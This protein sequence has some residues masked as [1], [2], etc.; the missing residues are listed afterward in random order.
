MNSF[1][2]SMTPEQLHEVLQS[3]LERLGGVEDMTKKHEKA[4]KENETQSLSIK[5]FQREPSNM[6]SRGLMK[7]E[8][9]MNAETSHAA[10]TGLGLAKKALADASQALV[11]AQKATDDVNRMSAQVRIHGEW[12][13]LLPT[14]L[15]PESICLAAGNFKRPDEPNGGQ[16]PGY[17]GRV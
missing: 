9:I 10:N 13:P 3:I 5:S 16:V 2:T 11:E 8:S 15:T 4:L 17:E 14:T 1:A 6:A 12:A 7:Q